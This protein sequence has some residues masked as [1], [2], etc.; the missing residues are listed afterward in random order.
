MEKKRSV[1]PMISLIVIVVIV[2]TTGLYFWGGKIA[3][4]PTENAA[5]TIAPV[6]SSDDL[7][8][9]ESDLRAPNSAP[10]VSGI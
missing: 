9:L 5:A 3:M 6:S 1:A 2:I 4:K 7:D 8:S 10:D